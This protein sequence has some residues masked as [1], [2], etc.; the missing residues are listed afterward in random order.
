MFHGSKNNKIIDLNE[1]M[2]FQ[3]KNVNKILLQ[4]IGI[5]GIAKGTKS[6]KVASR[7]YK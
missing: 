5:L 2:F 7:T 1:W 6:S 4:L 3:Y